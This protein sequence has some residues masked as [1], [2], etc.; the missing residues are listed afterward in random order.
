MPWF[1]HRYLAGKFARRKMI[2]AALR[3]RNWE[4]A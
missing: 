3:N 1:F 2:S 4:Q